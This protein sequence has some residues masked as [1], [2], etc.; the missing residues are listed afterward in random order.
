MQS[1]VAFVFILFY[2]MNINMNAFENLINIKWDFSLYKLLDFNS[3][4]GSPPLRPFTDTHSHPPSI[5]P[6]PCLLYSEWCALIMCFLGS[7]YILDIPDNILFNNSSLGFFSV[8]LCVCLSLSPVLFPLSFSFV[9]SLP[10]PSPHL[11]PPFSPFDN[12]YEFMLVL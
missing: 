6:P 9:V 5:P 1:A 7:N 2:F 12:N 11:F 8:C 10:G 4:T 3:R